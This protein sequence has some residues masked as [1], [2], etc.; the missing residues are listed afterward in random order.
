MVSAIKRT[1]GIAALGLFTLAST[2]AW[3]G[4]VAGTC[5]DVVA[6]T[7][8]AAASGPGMHASDVD[9]PPAVAFSIRDRMLLAEYRMLQRDRAPILLALDPACN[10]AAAQ[11]LERIGARVTGRRDAI[12][13]RSEEQTSE[14]Q[15][16]MRTSYA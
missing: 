1:C 4:P 5:A 6:T 16:L 9:D 2:C 10:A 8:D 11:A 14:L 3:A 15:S 13:Y 12:G 7:P